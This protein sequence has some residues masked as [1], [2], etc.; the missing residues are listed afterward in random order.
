MAGGPVGLLGRT[1]PPRQLPQGGLLSRLANE[2]I[3]GRTLTGLLGAFSLPGDVYARRTDPRSDEAIERAFDLASAVTLGA[4]A[5]PAKGMELRAGVGQ[6]RPRKVKVVPVHEHY[7]EGHLSKVANEMSKLGPPT[8]RVVKGND[9]Q[10]Y[11]IEGTHR[12]RA[13]EASDTPVALRV[14]DD[15]EEIDLNTL[16]MDIGGWF[17]DETK[18]PYEEFLRWFNPRHGPSQYRKPQARLVRRAAAP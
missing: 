8:I 6:A 13:A 12:L 11:A 14:L 5:I 10:F 9:G 2:T 4:G 16:D 1:P 17:D 3:T 18:I 15:S 7:D